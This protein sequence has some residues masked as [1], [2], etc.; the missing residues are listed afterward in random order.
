MKKY[1]LSVDQ[2]TSA[3]KAFLV[4]EKGHIVRRHSIAHQQYYPQPNFV[5]HDAEE[6][7]ANTVKAIRAVADG[8]SASDIAGL[9]IANQRETTVL[10]DRETGKPAGR[11]LVWQDTRADRPCE[12][13]KAHAAMIARTTGLALSPYYSAAKASWVLDS[14]QALA[15]RA[16]A[17]KIC[18][19]TVDSYLIYRLSGNSVHATDVTNASRTQ[20]MDLERCQWDEQIVGLFRIPM[21]C[22]PKIMPSDAVFAYTK[23]DGIPSGIPILGVMGDSHAA[24]FGHGCLFAGSAKATYGTGSS[25][26]MNVG[27]RPVLSKS[28]L[29]SSVGF[30]F[31]GKTY[32]ALE[33]NITCSGDT[34]VWLSQELGLIGEPEEAQAL[35]AIAPDTQGVYLVPA[36][37]GLGA[38]YFDTDAR[39]ILCGMSRGTTKAHV[40]RAAQESIAYQVCD[41]VSAIEEDS[42]KKLSVLNADGRPC[43]NEVLMQFQADMLGCTVNCPEATELSALGAAYMGGISAGLYSG[44]E[45]LLANQA[46]GVSYGAVTDASRRRALLDGWHE[47]VWRA[48]IKR[49]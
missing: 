29:S 26:M 17:G 35:A 36:F 33:G 25:V 34:L 24:L 14:D 43:R 10:W 3:S 19:G 49:S 15:A 18:F 7:W 13:I 37:A 16:A 45:T 39:A 2:S 6:I 30:S 32:Y 27:E 1:M 38:P 48:R 5:E 9:A 31:Q 28:G 12:R 46:N 22:L 11:A 20:L 8:I 4:D 47:A 21:R 40:A 42:G 44:L 23:C 41:V